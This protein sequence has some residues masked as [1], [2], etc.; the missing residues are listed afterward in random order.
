MDHLSLTQNIKDELRHEIIRL[1]R[2][3]FQKD[4]QL[5][6]LVNLE[7]ESKYM[8]DSFI[9]LTKFFASVFRDISDMKDLKKLNQIQIGYLLKIFDESLQKSL[10]TIDQN[11]DNILLESLA[12]ILKELVNRFSSSDFQYISLVI[13]IRKLLFD[14]FIT[15]D[16]EGALLTVLRRRTNTPKEEYAQVSSLNF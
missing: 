11:I 3:K 16:Y 14:G 9:K 6:T 12:I 10:S 7:V 13:G 5:S 4:S 15:T 1:N 8:H 2:R